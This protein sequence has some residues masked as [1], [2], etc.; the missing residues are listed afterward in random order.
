[1]RFINSAFQSV[2]IFHLYLMHALAYGNPSATD[3]LNSCYDYTEQVTLFTDRTLY[4]AGE[5]ILFSAFLHCNHDSG[6]DCL[7]QVMYIDIYMGLNNFSIKQKLNIKNGKASGSIFIP[8]NFQTGNYYIR[9][10][11]NYQKNYLTEDITYCEILILNPEIPLS[12]SVAEDPID[13]FFKGGSAIY[14]L[15]AKGVIIVN[16]KENNITYANIVSSKNEMLSPVRFINPD[17]GIFEFTPREGEEYFV[18]IHFT[19]S[20]SLIHPIQNIVNSGWNLATR[21]DDEYI[22]I[23]LTGVNTKPIHDGILVIKDQFMR[24]VFVDSIQV[25]GN[26][27]QNAIP[28]NLLDAKMNY[29]CIKNEDEDIHLFTAVCKPYNEILPLQL[30]TNKSVC[31]SHEAVELTI[32]GL[33]GEYGTYANL[34]VSVILKGSA[35]YSEM[36]DVQFE[37]DEAR[38]ILHENSIRQNSASI[39]KILSEDTTLLIQRLPEIKDVSLTGIV[40]DAGSQKPVSNC[41]VYLS[42]LG[43]EPQLHVC[44]TK[45]N[46]SFI[47][48][49]NNLSGN[50][51]LFVGVDYLQHSNREILIN[52]DFIQEYIQPYNSLSFTIGHHAVYEELFINMQ[53]AKKFGAKNISYVSTDFQSQPVFTHPDFSVVL[54]DYIELSTMQEVFT[55][56]VPFTYLRREKD[57]FYFQMKNPETYIMIDNPL[58]LFDNVPV[59]NISSILELSPATIERID[60]IYQEYF[61]GV[62]KFNGIINII[63]KESQLEHFEYPSGTVFF[64]YQTITPASRFELPETLEEQNSSRNIPYFS[65]ILYWNT[66]LVLRDSPIKLEFTTGDNGSEYQII[67]RGITSG[68]IPCYGEEVIR[69]TRD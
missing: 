11:T 66:N 55:E 10:Y 57:S 2:V 34:V 62:H 64:D 59:F 33:D 5:E 40:L 68:G 6:Y 23:S 37:S 27:W 31:S 24:V 9:A 69:I 18:K 25:S 26:I 65:N 3:T 50:R 22:N 35:Q 60:I 46:G 49:L 4:I 21:W 17:Q 1:M 30:E 36:K 43:S 51:K 8:S 38:A 7:S 39:H 13:F 29:I 20:D 48:S 52:N 58:I 14:G 56:I 12:T 44:G 61:L 54:S 41:E 42:V 47:F 32:K 45:K 28:A 15:L 16:N 63:S 53:V 67:V 19:D